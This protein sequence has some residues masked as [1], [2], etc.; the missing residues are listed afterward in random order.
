M[1]NSYKVS[2]RKDAA[3]KTNAPNKEGAEQ[4]AKQAIERFS[5]ERESKRAT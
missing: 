2:F 3:A 1:Y 5:G 4:G